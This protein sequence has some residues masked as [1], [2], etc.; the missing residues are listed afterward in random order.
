MAPAFCVRVSSVCQGRTRVTEELGGSSRADSSSVTV[1]IVCELLATGGFCI[2]TKSLSVNI[3]PWVGD[4]SF[5][6][7]RQEHNCQQLDWANFH[8]SV[9]WILFS[10]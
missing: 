5:T 6:E 9:G 3:H 1:R 2:Q 8:V 4:L 10:S 7:R